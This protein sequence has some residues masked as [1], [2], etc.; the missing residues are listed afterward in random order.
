MG[1]SNSR[2]DSGSD[3]P[4]G[5][6]GGA[7]EKPPKSTQTIP[8]GDGNSFANN[9][10]MLK[11][12]RS[13][14]RSASGAD[15]TEKY[16]TQ[17]VPIEKLSEILKGKSAKHGVNGIVSDVFVVSNDI[18]FPYYNVCDIRHCVTFYSHKFFLNMPI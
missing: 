6:S 15:V 17:L 11:A 1:N 2:S 18:L 9:N 7:K 14:S 8:K 10:A 12:E 13:M 5:G 4:N 16:L 3:A